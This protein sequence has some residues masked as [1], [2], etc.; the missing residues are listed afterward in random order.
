MN[1]N[2]YI[3]GIKV[4]CVA[5]VL[6]TTVEAAAQKD[7]SD[8]KTVTREMTL[9]REY[10]P[11]VQDAS[12]V[13][14]LPVVKEPQIKKMP[15]SYSTFAL[16][17]EPEKELGILGSGK[18]MTDM[19]FNK[20]RGYLNLGFGN[21]MNLNGDLGYHILSTEKDFLGAYFSHRST[22]GKIKYLETDEKQKAKLNDNLGAVNYKHE[23]EKLSLKL[24]AQYGY[25]AFNYYGFPGYSPSSDISQSP[26]DNQA[27]QQIYFNA[28][29]ASKDRSSFNYLLDLDYRNFSQKYADGPDTDGAKENNIGL[30]LDLNAGFNGNNKIGLG[31]LADYYGYSVPEALGNTS[32]NGYSNYAEITLSPYYAVEGSNWNVKL[33]ANV[34]YISGDNDKFFASPNITANVTVADATVIYGNFL[35]EINSNSMY[36]VALDNRYVDPTGRIKPSRTWLD[37]TIG[38]KS[39]IVP[40]FWFDIF[41]GYKITDNDH[42]YYADLNTNNVNTRWGNM[43]APAYM[44]SKLFRIGA[45]VKY[46]YQQFLDFSLKGVYNSWKVSDSDFFIIGGTNP[47]ERAYNKPKMEIDAAI[48]VKP[49]DKLTLSLNYYLGAGRYAVANSDDIKM[50][51]INELNLKG[52]YAINDMFGVYAKLNNL[53][54]QKYD[55]Y[56]GYTAQGFNAMLG[57]NLNF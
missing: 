6:G 9:E 25:T 13:N 29:V 33:G 47:T 5:A 51:N 7:K 30:T 1:T 49:M 38:I 22:N 40:G 14:S 26:M 3:T 12:K 31:V 17:V 42:F 52:S 37:G 35:G 27:N 23:F 28:G 34:M 8:D 41:A 18:V 20:R 56:Y 45:N 55:L 4:L 19:D 46:S 10:D 39:G 11:S 21:Y 54:F 24:A 44:N 32:F 16:P 15:I 2:L 53:M 50:K 43:F 48:D 57:I 36:Q